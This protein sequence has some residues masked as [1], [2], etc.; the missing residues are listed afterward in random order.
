MIQAA[1]MVRK[2][3]IKSREMNASPCTRAPRDRAAILGVYLIVQ[4]P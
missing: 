2:E 1:A 3:V 4:A